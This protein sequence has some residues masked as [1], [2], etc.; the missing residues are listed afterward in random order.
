M[1]THHGKDGVVK[2]GANAVAEVDNWSVTES[3]EVAEDTAMGDTWRSHIAGKTI[4]S[5]Q[6]SLTCHWDETDTQGQQALGVGASVTLGLY[7][8]G[9]ASGATYKSGLATITSVGLTVTK[10][11]VTQRSFNFQG[12]GALTEQAVAP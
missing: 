2:V 1:G 7:P 4:N 11:G 8:E 5:W 6:G 10:D 12:N 9:T 3:A